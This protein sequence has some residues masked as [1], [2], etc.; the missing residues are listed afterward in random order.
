MDEKVTK[1]YFCIYFC[2]LS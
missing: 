1:C 2:H